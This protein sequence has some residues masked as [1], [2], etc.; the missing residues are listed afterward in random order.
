VAGER[1][2]ADIVRERLIDDPFVSNEDFGRLVGEADEA[3]QR[4]EWAAELPEDER[5]EP[6]V[7]ALVSCMQQNYAE[8]ASV[9][10]RVQRAERSA[11]RALAHRALDYIACVNGGDAIEPSALRRAEAE[12]ETAAWGFLRDEETEPNV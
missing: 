8:Y 3:D 11:V 2:E 10:E 4:R 1:R 6:W 7:E 9:M 5:P 12:L